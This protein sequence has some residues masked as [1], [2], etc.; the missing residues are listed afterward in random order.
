[1]ESS[2]VRTPPITLRK[3]VIYMILAILM[4][5]PDEREGTGLVPDS[6]D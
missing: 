5:I 1:M 4:H 2:I 6:R 3:L